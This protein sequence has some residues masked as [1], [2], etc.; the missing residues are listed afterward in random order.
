MADFKP[1]LDLV[2]KHEGGFIDHKSDPGGATNYGISLRYLQSQKI[3]DADLDGDNDI[4]KEDVKILTPDQASLLY[5]KEFW[6]KNNVEPINSQRVANMFFGLCVNMGHNRATNILKAALMFIVKSKKAFD[7]L[8]ISIPDKI[9]ALPEDFV[10]KAYKDEA[11][12]HYRYLAA[13]NKNLKVF[14]K[15]WLNRIDSY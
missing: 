6:D 13:K 2:L 4:D 7:E 8:G 10:I 9:N 12:S 3:I 15:G 5:R 1:A 14:L 11:K